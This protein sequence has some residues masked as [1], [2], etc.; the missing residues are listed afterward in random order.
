MKDY[1]TTKEYA[2]LMGVHPQT[3]RRW[4]RQGKVICTR[5]IGNHR[6]F[7][8]PIVTKGKIIGFA[9]I[10][11]TD[12]K[13]DLETQVKVLEANKVDE[14]IKDLGSGMNYKKAGFIK[15][16]SM[17]L[18]GQIKELVLTRKDRLLSFGSE[19]IFGICKQLNVKEPMER[20]C[21]DIVEI[22]TVFTSKIYGLR[23]HKNKKVLAV[24]A[25]N[26]QL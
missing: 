6:R 14:V 24:K 4:N 21:L 22:I 7:K 23:S 2:E 9:R 26:A 18:Q 17:L 25:A 5:T 10:S 15:L 8:L 19:L 16:L 3:V 11:S 13:T 1:Y 12:Q 20:F